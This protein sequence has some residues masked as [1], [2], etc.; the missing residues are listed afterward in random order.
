MV[1]AGSIVVIAVLLRLT[2]SQDPVMFIALMAACVLFPIFKKLFLRRLD[3]LEIDV[4]FLLLFFVS[5]VW[6]AVA[7]LRDSTG[8]SLS[9][10]WRPE[11]FWFG[12]YV[13]TLAI[14]AFILGYSTPFGYLCARLV[15]NLPSTYSIK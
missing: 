2:G 4:V 7:L 14:A 3:I 9:A 5:Y 13:S 10:F 8:S 15:P 6:R 11:G 12:C 1:F